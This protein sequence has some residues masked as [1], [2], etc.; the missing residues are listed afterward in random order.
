MG[1]ILI[2]IDSSKSLESKS[3]YVIILGTGLQGEKPKNI[4]KYRLDKAINY[5]DKYPNTIFI[6]SGGQGKDEV[7]S[8]SKTMKDYL[9]SYSIPEKN[10]IE[11]N[12]STTAL[13]N[14]NFSQK[15]I[16]NSVENIGII[17]NDFHMYRI[18]C[19]ANSLSYK[20]NPI[21]TPTPLLNKVSLFSREAIAII[22]YKIFIRNI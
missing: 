21:Y 12:Q 22:Y 10:I 16:P 19:F 13:E 4:L 6:V 3:E 5:Y 15:F 20:M 7:I 11:E 2:D 18:K 14:L 9:I 17:S 1:I 8:E